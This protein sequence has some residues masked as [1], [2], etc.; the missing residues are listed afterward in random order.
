MRP[1]PPAELIERRGSRHRR[2]LD[3]VADRGRRAARARSTTRPRC[4]DPSTAIVHRHR[5]RP[6]QFRG[7]LYDPVGP[8]FESLRA[9]IVESSRRGAREGSTPA[10]TAH[11]VLALREAFCVVAMQTEHDDV[12]TSARPSAARPSGRRAG[13]ADLRDVRA[14]RARRSSAGRAQQLLELSTPVVRLWDGIVGVPLVGTLDS[15][16]AQVVMESPAAGH[17]RRARAGRDPRHHRR[18]RPWTPSSRSTCSRR[19]R[20]PGSWARTASSAASARRP[21]RR[22]CSSASTSPRSR[23]GPRSRTRSPPPSAGSIRGSRAASV[24]GA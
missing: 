19:S 10:E 18:A 17:R 16:R 22:S 4:V 13:P 23:P 1:L 3:P 21:R 20:P 12:A 14:R 15:A 24:D 8:D 7:R 5:R 6:A 9:L 11:G 2:D